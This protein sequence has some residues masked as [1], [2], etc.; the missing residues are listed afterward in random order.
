M[1][2]VWGGLLLDIGIGCGAWPRL[3]V[4]NVAMGLIVQN[5]TR[6]FKRSLP[7]PLDPTRLPGR[8]V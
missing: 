2:G 7:C 1:A 8:R 5:R 6:R 3:A 4:S